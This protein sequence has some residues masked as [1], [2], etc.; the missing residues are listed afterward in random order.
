MK[1]SK[2]RFVILDILAKNLK[3]P[4]PQVVSVEHIAR[5]MGI[6]M[7]TAIDKMKFLSANGDVVTDMEG[8]NALI[9]SKGYTWLEEKIRAYTG[10][11]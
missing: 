6:S 10:T 9:T 2:D 3:E 11:S 7:R 4:N 1:V 5:C 8:R